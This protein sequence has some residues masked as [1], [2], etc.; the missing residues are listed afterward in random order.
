MSNPED[1]MGELNSLMSKVMGTQMVQDVVHAYDAYATAAMQALIGA[2]G[3]TSVTAD[4]IA[5]VAWRVADAMM[6]E[7]KKR[8]IGGMAP[9]E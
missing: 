5:S 4:L 7:R 3:P 2:T 8:G 9:G 6:T 1:M